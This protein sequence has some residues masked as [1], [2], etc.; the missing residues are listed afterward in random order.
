MKNIFNINY[1]NE[2][3]SSLA[4]LFCAE[5]CSSISRPKYV[6]GRNVY[7]ESVIHHIQI[8]GVIDDFTKDNTYLG[9]PIV[10]ITE[11][12]KNALVLNAAGGRPLSAKK[13]LEKEGLQN[14]DYF[15]FLKHS[16]IESLTPVVFNENFA[17]D[18]FKNEAEYV[19]IYNILADETSR[20]IFRRLVNFRLNY[21]LED[22]EG[23][24]NREA[25]QYFEDFL[26]LA[27][28]GETFIDIGGF[29]GSNTLDFIK[30]C[31]NYNAVHLFEPEPSNFVKCVDVLKN[32]S[33][34]YCYPHGL[35]D[36]K[37]TLRLESQG[38]ASRITDN[39]LISINVDSLD[40]VLGDR[41][42]P[43]FI[44][45]DI[46]GAEM[47]AI[48]GAKKTITRYRP[49]LAV[50]IYHNVGDFWRIP[51]KILSFNNDYSIFVRHY[52]E[53]IYETV[54]FFIPKKS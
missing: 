19:S 53:S 22:L 8:N 6:L 52:T 1:H 42:K 30:R 48:E 45:M 11:V 46:E 49:R 18:F 29:N 35:S 21:S 27:P 44:K 5:F 14:L 51:K 7:A 33:N 37:Q 47:L 31:P 24:S 16:N 39:G 41:F 10:K 17:K 23:F 43:T 20:E 3:Q 9:Y 4:R 12:E 36:R 15:S 25:E 38:S 28:D 40:D 32:K 54:M 34:I 50:C 2:N 26:Q 13:Q